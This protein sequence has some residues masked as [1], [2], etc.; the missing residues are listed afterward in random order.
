MSV[1]TALEKLTKNEE[2]IETRKILEINL[3]VFVCIFPQKTSEKRKRKFNFEER[4]RRLQWLTTWNMK[5]HSKKYIYFLEW[6]FMFQV[7]SHCNLLIRS[8]KLNLRFRFSE[9]FWG[10]IQTKTKRL[11]SRIFL[12]SILSSF[13]VNFSNAVFTLKRL[14]R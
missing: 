13:F 6:S 1:N 11:I 2:R 14:P 12:V 8:S 3:F 10:K 5:L 7:V 4:I 9:V